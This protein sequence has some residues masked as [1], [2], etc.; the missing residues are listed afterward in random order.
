MNQRISEPGRNTNGMYLE[1]HSLHTKTPGIAQ[2]YQE[3]KSFDS[4]QNGLVQL[5]Q[6]SAL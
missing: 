1:D 3:V 6:L 4:P 5:N 2:K